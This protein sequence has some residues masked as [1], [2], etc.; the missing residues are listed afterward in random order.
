[1]AGSKG[2]GGGGKGGSVTPPPNQYSPPNQYGG[3]N[4]WYNQQPQAPYN[5]MMD[6]YGSGQN[7][8]QPMPGYY[9]QFPA[10]GNNYRPYQ[11]QPQPAPPPD[12]NPMPTLPGPIGGQGGQTGF[13]IGLEPGTNFNNYDMNQIATAVNRSQFGDYY[14]VYRNEPQTNSYL[15][16]PYYANHGAAQRSN[17]DMDNPFSVRDTPATNGQTDGGYDVRVPVGNQSG[18]IFLPQPGGGAN[19]LPSGAANAFGYQPTSQPVQSLN[20]PPQ[21]TATRTRPDGRPVGRVGMPILDA[22]DRRGGKGRDSGPRSGYVK[23]NQP[24]PQVEAMV[25]PGFGGY[26]QNARAI[27]YGMPS[28]ISSRSVR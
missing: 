4:K 26:D 11:P 27:M 18:T 19:A 25:D 14:P 21:F 8:M 20:A 3:G 10:G 2:G 6:V 23:Y 5:P 15:N 1:M 28:Y 17:F 9:N 13:P 12:Y 22:A 24:Q 16:N 7:V